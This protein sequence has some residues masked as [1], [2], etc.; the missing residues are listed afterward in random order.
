MDPIRIGQLRFP[1]TIYHRSEAPDPGGSGMIETLINP[2]STVADIVPTGPIMFYG[3]I[4]ADFDKPV[5]HKIFT[6]WI[7]LIDSTY[8]ITRT[9]MTPD[10]RKRVEYFRVWR[11]ME[12][13]GR[14]R[15]LQYDAQL[16]RFTYEID[17]SVTEATT[18]TEAATAAGTFAASITETAVASDTADAT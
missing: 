16:E 12:I 18:A 15:F 5:T 10:G 17:V 14:H 8:L 9:L 3:S 4:Q 2:I 11:I 13:E 1:I 7:P 6:R